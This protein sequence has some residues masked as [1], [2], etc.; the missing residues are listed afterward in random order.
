MRAL[1]ILI[2]AVL[3][4]SEPHSGFAADGEAEA[5]V[6]RYYL[7]HADVA[8]RAAVD[9]QLSGDR[10]G[11]MRQVAQTVAADLS[12]P[13]GMRMQATCL[14]AEI[15]TDESVPVLMAILERDI[16]ERLGL[17]ACA[18]PGLGAVGDRR[19]VP[20]LRK[21][22]EQDRD[23]LIG[24][25][26]MAISAIAAMATEDEAGF[27]ESRAHVFPVREDVF[28]ALAR[29][30]T[31]SSVEVLI[32]GLQSGEEPEINAASME[33]LRRIGAVALPQLRAALENQPDDEMKARLTGLIAALE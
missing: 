10:T 5:E 20:L 21:V 33:G 9:A 19:A 13:S 22:A 11:A 14:L 16:E 7:D 17:W 23:D 27:L 30:G 25:D 15:A 26:H 28:V 4:V 29:I 24:M 32:S 3:V 6:L 12:A 18:I 8:G 1:A 2:S 31:P